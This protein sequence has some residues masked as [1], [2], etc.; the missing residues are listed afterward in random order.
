MKN[1]FGMAAWTET[2][3]P[4]CG[5]ECTN[6]LFETDSVEEIQPT[7]ME[8]SLECSLFTLIE[9]RHSHNL[10]IAIASSILLLFACVI[11]NFVA[12]HVAITF[13]LAFRSLL[14]F[15]L[16]TSNSI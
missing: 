16:T 12:C 4:Y 6:V 15:I 11:E 2:L 14:W 1:C 5:V 7:T 9:W 8:A 10:D 3:V 13:L